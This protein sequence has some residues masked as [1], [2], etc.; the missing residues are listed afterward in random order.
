MVRCVRCRPAPEVRRTLAPLFADDLHHHPLAAS[1]V[2]LSVED[3]LPRPQ[4]ESPL[5]HRQH[6]LVVD[7]GALEMGVAIILA[8]AV[9]LVVAAGGSQC[10]HPLPKVFPGA[11]LVIVDPDSGGNVHRTN[12]AQP[13]AYAGGAAD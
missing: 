1:A 11:L 2:E 3:L 13:L 9:V 6:H 7:E 4:I 8:G 5:S 12:K 10:L